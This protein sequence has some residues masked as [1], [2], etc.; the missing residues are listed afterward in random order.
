MNKSMNNTIEHVW[1]DQNEAVQ[2]K[3]YRLSRS[4]EGR[5]KTELTDG[6]STKWAGK[7]WIALDQV[8]STNDYAAKMAKQGAPH[9]TLVTAE[10][11]HGG[12]GRRGRSWVMPKGSSIAASILVRPS[13]EPE[14]AS[15]M[16]LVAG[17][18]AAKGI[19]KITGLDV[20]LK[21]PNDGVIE[22]RKVSGTLTEMSMQQG[23]VDHIVIGTG[24]NVNVTEFP[25]ELKGIATSLALEK[26]SMVTRTEVLCAYVEEF[27]K[28]YEQFM[29]DRDMTGLQEEYQQL[30]VNCDRQVRVLE[31]GREYEGIAR[32]IDKLGQ[33]LVEKEDGSIIKVYAGEVSVRGIYQYV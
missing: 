21:W 30:L 6:F 27:E 5:L 26:G 22:G 32:G 13:L 8:D 7:K 23:T 28:L 29:T 25:E 9:G 10:Y 20:K 33:L 1:N 15:M 2:E 11:Q 31:P 16:T 4:S 17:M 14:K 12:K 24:I 18:A 3:G 19:R